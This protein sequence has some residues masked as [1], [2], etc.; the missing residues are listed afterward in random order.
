LSV[1]FANQTDLSLKWLLPNPETGSEQVKI[2]NLSTQDVNLDT[3]QID[4]I[5]GGSKPIKL[6]G[7]IRVGNGL[8]IELSSAM[9]NNSGDKL[10]LIKDGVVYEQTEY[11]GASKGEYWFKD[12]HDTWCWL[13]PDLLTDDY[14]CPISTP[15]QTPTPTPIPTA[16]VYPYAAC[17]D[18]KIIKVNPSPLK[19]QQEKVMIYN[20]HQF[21]VSLSG[22]QIDDEVGHG[23]P[24]DLS[25]SIDSYGVRGV[26]LSKPIFNNSGD[27]VRLLCQGKLIDGLIYEKID[28]GS[29]LVKDKNNRLCLLPYS[30]WQTEYQQI[31]CLDNHQE[32]LP[33]LDYKSDA[34]HKTKSV[35][36]KSPAM[37]LGL[38]TRPTVKPSLVKIYN[39]PKSIDSQT[40]P[41]PNQW[42]NLSSIVFLAW[43]FYRRLG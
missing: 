29:L 28:K 19:D 6:E 18:L 42:L 37:V 35:K 30:F 1:V 34:D 20:P 22:Y 3:W 33:K 43:R 31:S 38:N 32:S 13:K 14:L 2:I 11:T 5:E 36:V 10:R 24:I 26:I 41:F 12:S 23:Q 21:R 9:F 17:F 8:I 16:Y 4:D 7:L 27:Q 25:G 39:Q 15:S 40:G